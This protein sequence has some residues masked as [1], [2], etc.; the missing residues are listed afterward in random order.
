MA[1][2][3]GLHTARLILFFSGLVAVAISLAIL[4]APGAFYGSY[5][6]ELGGNLNLANELKAPAGA[7]LVAGV[8]MFTGVFRRDFI[9]ASLVTAIV[10]YLGYGLSRGLSIVLDGMPDSDMLSAAG[11]ELLIGGVC[12][13][14][15]IQVRRIHP[16]I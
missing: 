14:T 15:L 4:F 5:G 10:I 7:L 6:I 3:S 1:V 12:L 16:T 2:F 11:I 8:L 13:V 9:V